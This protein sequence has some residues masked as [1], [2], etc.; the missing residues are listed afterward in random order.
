MI[1]YGKDNGYNLQHWKYIDKYRGRGGKWIYV[2]K[3]SELFR[4]N[5]NDS[6]THI[7]TV[8][9]TRKD[10]VN[11]KANMKELLSSRKR[12]DA[13]RKK[14]LSENKYGK[15]YNHESGK[16]A[17]RYKSAKDMSDING[18]EERYN[19]KLINMYERDKGVEN[20]DRIELMDAL[21]EGDKKQYA[22]MS[23]IINKYLKE[24]KK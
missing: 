13:A 3:N 5:K 6:N 12:E 15:G 18:M 19:A 2:Y 1:Y 20:R 24:N 11:G 16:A 21:A 4:K 9:E 8:S 10:V 14:R 7:K 17:N 22:K 23:K